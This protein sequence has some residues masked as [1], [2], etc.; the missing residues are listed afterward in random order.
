[1]ADKREKTIIVVIAI[2]L[3]VIAGKRLLKKEKEPISDASIVDVDS[4][5]ELTSGE[6]LI[7]AKMAPRSKIEFVSESEYIILEGEEV[8]EG[9][10]EVVNGLP[11][12]KAGMIVTY[13]D[14]GYI[15]HITL[16][17]KVEY[18]KEK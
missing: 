9:K 10:D 16:N 13:A 8:E 6:K 1:M 14:D 7:P 12:V 17:D 4:S 5:F 18:G 3:V 15:L 11:E 2:I